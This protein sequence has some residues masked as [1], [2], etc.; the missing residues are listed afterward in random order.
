MTAAKLISDNGVLS[1]VAGVQAAGGNDG[2]LEIQTTNS[3]GVAITAITIDQSQNVG[4]AKT[5]NLL[6]TFGYKN[7]LIN[8]DMRIDQR[9]AGTATANTISSYVIDRWAVQQTT[10]GKLVAQ[11]NSGSVTPP[12]GFKNY[13]GVVSQS[14]YSVGSGDQF[15]IQQPIEGYNVSDFAYGTAFAATSTVSF[16]ARS[17]LTG[18]FSAYILL[19]NG[20]TFQSYAF[21]Y[22]LPTA[23]TWTYV[24]ATIPGNTNFA[25]D[26]TNGVGM[27]L[28][29]NLGSGSTFN[30]T[31]GSWQAGNTGFV[32]GSQS[33]VGTSGATFYITGV[34]L[35]K[36]TQPTSFDFREIGEELRKCQRYFESTAYP[37]ATFG[38]GGVRIG[39]V[40][41]STTFSPGFNYL[42]PKRTNSPTV[43]LYSR[44]GNAG[45]MS[46]V[47]NGADI[48]GTSTAPNIGGTGF[49]GCTLGT[50]QILAAGVEC[51]WTASAEL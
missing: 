9:Y 8:G 47:A 1:G 22:S 45:K 29:I 49:W 26:Q 33:V 25:G 4:F 6:N 23:N 48:G 50:A 24:T 36:G 19:Y 40:T 14:A 2:A 38:I 34:Q 41:T 43:T 32:S 31:A 10:T 28:R 46:L 51:G 35:E 20:S 21:T 37:D 5:V 11:Q 12:P 3:L 16:W 17:S 30:E 15:L 13:L 42:A 39:T 27:W 7:R 18:T 44:N